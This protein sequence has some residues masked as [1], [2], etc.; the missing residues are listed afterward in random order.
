MSVTRVVVA[1]ACVAGAVAFWNYKQ[2]PGSGYSASKPAS[3]ETSSNDYA[4]LGRDAGLLYG[5]RCERATLDSSIVEQSDGG[6][7]FRIRCRNPED[8][9]SATGAIFRFV[10]HPGAK[11][12]DVELVSR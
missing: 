1:V 7:A 6:L 2:G 8:V 3:A 5:I 4:A 11:I 12:P 10:G 9:W